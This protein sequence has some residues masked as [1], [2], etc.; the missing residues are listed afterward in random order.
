MERLYLLGAMLELRCLPD[1]VNVVVGDLALDRQEVEEDVRLLDHLYVKI[2][3][4][5]VVN[6]PVVEDPGGQ[7]EPDVLDL[8][9]TS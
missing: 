3:T 9:I 8:V 7:L 6:D 5:N 1:H 2:R 4:E